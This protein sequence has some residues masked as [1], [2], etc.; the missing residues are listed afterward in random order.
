VLLAAS[1]HTSTFLFSWVTND[2]APAVSSSILVCHVYLFSDFMTFVQSKL[3]QVVELDL[4]SGGAGL[5]L[6]W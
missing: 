6:D 3:G 5:I 4:Y 1:T 2:L